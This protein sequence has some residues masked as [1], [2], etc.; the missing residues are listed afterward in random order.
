VTEISSATDELAKGIEQLN[1]MVHQMDQSTQPN[2]SLAG[3]T[4]KVGQE[5]AN[6]SQSIQQLLL[7][8]NNK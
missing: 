2:A 5:M 3:E 6:Q 8:C 7:T 4:S 1:T